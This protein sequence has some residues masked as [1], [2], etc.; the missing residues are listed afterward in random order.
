MR[1]TDPSGVEH[2]NLSTTK[3]RAIFRIANRIL[4]RSIANPKRFYTPRFKALPA[5]AEWANDYGI[6][7]LNLCCLWHSERLCAHEA[8]L[9][10]RDTYLFSHIF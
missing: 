7:R 8:G 1:S 6:H 10:S 5:A 4:F 3:F 2:A 9:R